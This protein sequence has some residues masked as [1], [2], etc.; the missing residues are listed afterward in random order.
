MTCWSF[1][2]GGRKHGKER[3]QE[4][5]EDAEGKAQAQK[6]QA[7]RRKNLTAKGAGS[8]ALFVTFPR[9]IQWPQS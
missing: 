9:F 1:D 7:T 4:T 2:T 6:R 3:P 8:P 5:S